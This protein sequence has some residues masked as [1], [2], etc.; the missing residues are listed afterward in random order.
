MKKNSCTTHT[1]LGQGADVLVQS[2]N[3]FNFPAWVSMG[4]SHTTLCVF[5]TAISSNLM[6]HTKIMN[7]VLRSKIFEYKTM[8]PYIPSFRSSSR[9]G[10]PMHN[11]VKTKSLLSYYYTYI[12]IYLAR[13]FAT[14]HS[15]SI[16][17]NVES[18]YAGE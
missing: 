4:R 6:K 17:H 16:N 8:M 9:S 2:T 11:R 5:S 15:G 7:T 14:N 1:G 10:L 18:P 3:L 13:L 12:Y